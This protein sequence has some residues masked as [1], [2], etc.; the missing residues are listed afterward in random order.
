MLAADELFQPLLTAIPTTAAKDV[1]ADLDAGSFERV[2][3]ITHSSLFAQDRNGPGLYS[4]TLTVSLFIDHSHPHMTEFVGEVYDGIWA[5]DQSPTAG[6]IPG[7]GAV[8]A[9]ERELS[10]FARLGGNV[11]MPNNIVTQYVGSWELAVREL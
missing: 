10:A 6:F 11:Q 5:W 7:V 8:K 9:I 2:P 1:N 4:V 3:L